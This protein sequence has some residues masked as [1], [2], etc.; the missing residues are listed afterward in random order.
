MKTRCSHVLLWVK[1]IH[2]AVQ[3]FRQLGFTVDY[4]TKEKNAQHAH[5]WFSEGAIIELLT[6]PSNARYFKWLIDVFAGRGA[7][8]RMIRWSQEGE[9]FCDVAL[10]S[11]DFDNDLSVMNREGVQTGRVIPW[12]RT[13]PNGQ[14]ISFRFVYPRSERLPFLVSPYNPPQYPQKTDHK[15]GA[16]GLSKVYMEVSEQ[17]WQS[18]RR[19]TDQDSIFN[20]KPGPTTKVTGIEVSGLKENLDPTLLHGSKINPAN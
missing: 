1:D 16:N 12:R 11:D 9:G 4:A 8:R 18:V 2:Q 13:K 6:S 17:D 5:I 14:K 20:I 10:V 7:G 3:D 15:N 19:L